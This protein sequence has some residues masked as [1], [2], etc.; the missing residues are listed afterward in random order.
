VTHAVRLAGHKGQQQQ[1][2]QLNSA[3]KLAQPGP[4]YHPSWKSMCTVMQACAHPVCCEDY[5]R[6][7]EV[8]LPTRAVPH[9]CLSSTPYRLS[10]GDR[11]RPLPRAHV[12]VT[13]KVVACHHL[14][15]ALW[16]VD[17]RALPKGGLRKVDACST[18][19]GEGGDSVT[20]SIRLYDVSIRKRLSTGGVPA[21]RRSLQQPVVVGALSWCAM[22]LWWL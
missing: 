14:A 12:A 1:Q 3:Y 9:T 7:P 2:Q 22:P 16:V 21:C 5:A 10:P 13:N 20:S 19:N 6:L 4:A 8:L 17:S 15:A 18:Y 11:A